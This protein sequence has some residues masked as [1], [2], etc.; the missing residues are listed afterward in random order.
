MQALPLQIDEKMRALSVELNAATYTESR[1]ELKS[2]DSRKRKRSRVG[3]ENDDRRSSFAR[4]QSVN[5]ADGL[6]LHSISA[7]NSTL[8]D[9]YGTVKNADKL[10]PF[11]PIRNSW[12]NRTLSSQKYPDHQSVSRNPHQNQKSSLLTS[13]PRDTR[14]QTHT[15]TLRRP[16]ADLEL[17]PDPS[18]SRANTP[19]G[20]GPR[21][22]HTDVSFTDI[23]GPQLVLTPSS[24]HHHKHTR[25]P[26][27][28]GRKHSQIID[29][30]DANL[31]ASLDFCSVSGAVSGPSMSSSGSLT[32]VAAADSSVVTIPIE[33]TTVI[34]SPVET[35]TSLAPPSL[36][37]TLP[38]PVPPPADQEMTNGSGTDLLPVIR[39]M[40]MQRSWT[41]AVSLS[42]FFWYNSD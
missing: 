42:S 30:S 11:S 31:N 38:A 27:S 36:S 41:M 15:N 5:C 4:S 10:V 25:L 13:S 1:S 32:I 34:A 33:A 22:E 28:L 37:K 24:T 35:A 29:R 12:S 14:T 23:P 16:L 39:P 7:S 17:V 20:S 9:A 19:A 26:A 2:N 6:A 3:R 40:N 8:S 18:A 21:R